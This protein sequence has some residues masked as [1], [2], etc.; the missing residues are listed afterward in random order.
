VRQQRAGQIEG[1]EVGHRDLLDELG[2]LGLL[3]EQPAAGA[4]VVDEDCGR[5]HVGDDRAGGRGDRHGVA[6][7]GR[8]RTRLPAA[9]PHLPG[10]SLERLGAARYQRDARAGRREGAPRRS[11]D[12]RRRS[13]HDGQTSG[14]L[15]RPSPPAPD[16]YSRTARK[17]ARRPRR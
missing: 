10:H 13:R 3:D 14:D 8:V 6:E 12:P 16:G 4:R 17:V 2:R 9:G 7:V 11:A 1:A 15:H 5:T